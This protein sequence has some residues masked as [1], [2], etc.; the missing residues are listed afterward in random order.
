MTM[1]QLLHPSTISLLHRTYL[2]FLL[3]SSSWVQSV[4]QPACQPVPR[5]ALVCCSPPAAV[6]IIIRVLL[7]APYHPF[8]CNEWIQDSVIRPSSDQS[9]S[10][11]PPLSLS[12]PPE[13]QSLGQ[14][15]IQIIMWNNNN[16]SSRI[17]V[18]LAIDSSTSINRRWSGSGSRWPLLIRDVV[19]HCHDLLW[20]RIRNK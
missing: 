4:S 12:P 5:V 17:S 10:L 11:S 3:S 15:C 20:G 6:L 19:R 8:Y 14:L 13:M 9:F 7:A 1:E 16:R 2:A 18:A